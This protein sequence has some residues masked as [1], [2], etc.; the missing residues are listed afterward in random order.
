MSNSGFMFPPVVIGVFVLIAIVLLRVIF[1]N[2]TNHTI[3]HS[4]AETGR[5]DFAKVE[6]YENQIYQ[7]QQ[8]VSKSKNDRQRELAAKKLEKILKL[9][10]KL[11]H[12]TE[13][14]IRKA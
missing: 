11:K 2:K 8:F 6:A 3:R 13:M 9:K 1:S 5:K 14:E 4:S 12:K 10:E 7:L